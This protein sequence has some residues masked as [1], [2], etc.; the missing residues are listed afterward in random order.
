M[1][2]DPWTRISRN[3]DMHSTYG[4][5]SL[6]PISRVHDSCSFSNQSVSVGADVLDPSNISLPWLPV[7]FVTSEIPHQSAED[8]TTSHHIFRFSVFHSMT[9][10]RLQL[11]RQPCPH[12]FMSYRLSKRSQRATEPLTHRLPGCGMLFATLALESGR[13]L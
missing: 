7:L 10:R 12:S 1:Q 3:A 2:Y 5:L 9:F 4:V 11:A 6:P 8:A 13:L